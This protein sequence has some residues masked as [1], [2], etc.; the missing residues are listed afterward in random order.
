MAFPVQRPTSLCATASRLQNLRSHRRIVDTFGCCDDDVA[1]NA[2]AAPAAAMSSM[3]SPVNDEFID[4][5]NV[6][7]DVSR[8][9]GGIE[10][11]RLRRW[12]ES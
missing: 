11:E 1:V 12:L 8:N 5:D 2:F 4:P 6:V 7:D 10:L 9:D 3:L